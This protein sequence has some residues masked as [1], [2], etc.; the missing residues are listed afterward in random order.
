M[1]NIGALYKTPA[2]VRAIHNIEI[3]TKKQVLKLDDII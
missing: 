2:A 3:S 1:F